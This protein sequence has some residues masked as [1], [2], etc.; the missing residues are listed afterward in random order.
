MSGS[1][2]GHGFMWRAVVTTILVVV[3]FLATDAE[4]AS[5]A[6]ASGVSAGSFHTC[7]VTTLGGL[8]CWGANSSGQLG[9]GTTI[10]SNTAVDVVGLT[11]GVAVVSAGVGHTCAVTTASGLKCWGQN[12]SGQL[13]D[14][15]TIS[16]NAPVDVVGLTSGVAGVSP[17]DFHTCARTTAGGLKCWGR[18][19]E[20]QLG[21]E[22]ITD[23]STPVDVIGF[24]GVVPPVPGVSQWGLIGLALALAAVAYVAVRRRPA[25]RTS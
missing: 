1:R 2:A 7:A 5:A 8:K 22:T 15:T 12:F 20:G 6:S 4:Q 10:S 25:L 3:A 19:L 14:G 17:G 13:G 16:S 18:N 21:D 11:S 9:D 24:L 23:R